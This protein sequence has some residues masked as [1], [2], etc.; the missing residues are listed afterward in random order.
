MKNVLI[1][2]GLLVIAC[3]ALYGAYSRTPAR[4]CATLTPGMAYMKINNLAAL[5]QQALNGNGKIASYLSDYFGQEK[6]DYQH[7]AYWE[8]I[9]AEK[10]DPRGMYRYGLSLSLDEGPRRKEGLAWLQKA[11]K[12]GCISSDCM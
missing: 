12:A 1:G 9:A 5:Q 2:L 11:R 10:H 3:A 6:Q 4:S 8:K 7:A